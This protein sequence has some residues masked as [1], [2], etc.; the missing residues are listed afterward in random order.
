MGIKST[1]TLSRSRA[2]ALMHDLR[3]KVYGA[4]A[5]IS[6]EDLGNVLDG[7]QELVCH[8]EG[9]PCFD[10]YLVEP[11]HYYEEKRVER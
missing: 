1:T 8:K 5:A 4:D 11:D 6:D 2:L 3:E 10:N 7:L 9:R